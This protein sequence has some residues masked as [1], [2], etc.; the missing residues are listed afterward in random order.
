[1]KDSD[2][3]TTVMQK[4]WEKIHSTCLILYIPLIVLLIIQPIIQLPWLSGLLMGIFAVV[5]TVGSIVSWFMAKSNDVLVVGKLVSLRQ[6]GVFYIGNIPYCALTVQFF[7]QDR[8]Q[9]TAT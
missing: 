2:M 4:I 9:I 8:Q 7:T 1:M 5:I 6:F 3:S